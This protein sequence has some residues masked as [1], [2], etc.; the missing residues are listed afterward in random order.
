M[1]APD[2]SVIATAI[3]AAL[4]PIAL[5]GT[6]VLLIL[7]FRWV[8][9]VAV[10]APLDEDAERQAFHDEFM[11]DELDDGDGDG[12][13][14]LADMG[15]AVMAYCPECGINSV[16]DFFEFYDRDTGEPLGDEDDGCPQCDGPLRYEGDGS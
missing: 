13:W 16:D 2:V 5:V 9:A 14:T 6:A 7:A 8:I 3:E 1:A 10:R 12:E 15:H 11:A 4:T